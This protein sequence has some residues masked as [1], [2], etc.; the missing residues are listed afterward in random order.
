MNKL[1]LAII[2]L[3]CSFFIGTKAFSREEVLAVITNDENYD[4][5]KFIASTN[6]ETQDLKTFYKDNYSNGNQV[7]REV[8]PTALLAMDGVVLDKRGE[9][10]VINLKSDNF[11][12]ENGGNVT[13]DT[14]Y[15]GVT[16][17]RRQ[18]S[19]ELVHGFD[20][21]KL[22]NQNNVIS[23]LHIEVNKKMFIGTVGVKNIRME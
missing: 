16:G 18:Y 9:H 8:L 3:C 7:G 17:E 5:C 1:S 14:L 13:I 10:T 6:D 4:V 23:K 21:W 20:G 19:I 15:N 2:F 22:L 12:F 11:D